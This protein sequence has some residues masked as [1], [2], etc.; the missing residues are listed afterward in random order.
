VIFLVFLSVGLMCIVISFNYGLSN[1]KTLVWATKN[2]SIS[3]EMS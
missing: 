3:P 2:I 1:A